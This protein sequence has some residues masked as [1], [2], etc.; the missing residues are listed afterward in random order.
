MTEINPTLCERC[1]HGHVCA[2]TVEYKELVR[3]I[4]DSPLELSDFFKVKIECK[5]Y[6]CERFRVKETK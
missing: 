3:R 5:W 4:N 2:H 1:T 6:I